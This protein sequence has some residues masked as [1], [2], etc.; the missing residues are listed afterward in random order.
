MSCRRKKF[1]PGIGANPEEWHTSISILVPDVLPVVCGFFR[2]NGFAIVSGGVVFFSCIIFQTGRIRQRKP[3][4]SDQFARLLR[5]SVPLF[6]GN[7]PLQSRELY[8]TVW[9][10]K[11]QAKSHQALRKLDHQSRSAIRP[12]HLHKWRNAAPVRAACHSACLNATTR[13]EL[14]CNST[15]SLRGY[16]LVKE[17][18]LPT[19]L[20]TV[21]PS[22]A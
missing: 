16:V 2:S 20:G 19:G 8:S 12:P 18:S 3:R 7:L 10:Q 13:K 15:C 5:T 1:N 4:R 9:P 17:R 6:H 14:P 22:A 11:S 21:Q